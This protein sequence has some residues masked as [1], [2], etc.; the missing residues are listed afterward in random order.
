MLAAGLAAGGGAPANATSLGMETAGP[1]HPTHRFAA[2]PHVKVQ[3][4]YQQHSGGWHSLAKFVN[5]GVEVVND[6]GGGLHA[7]VGGKWHRLGTFT[8][9]LR[10]W[11]CADVTI[12]AVANHLTV[13]VNGTRVGSLTTSIVPETTVQV[14][15]ATDAFSSDPYVLDDVRIDTSDYSLTEPGPPTVEPAVPTGLKVVSAHGG[16]VELDWDDNTGSFGHYQVYRNNALIADGPAESRFVDTG[17]TVGA[18]YEYRVSAGSRPVYGNWTAGVS[19]VVRPGGPPAATPPVTGKPSM[20]TGLKVVAAH[21]S[22]VEL[23]WDDNA[24]S[25]GHYQVYRNNKMIADGPAESRFVDTAVTVGATYEYR[26]GAGSRPFYGD[27]STGVSATVR[28]GGPP[29][30]APP[31]TTRPSMPTGLKV[32]AA[33]GSGVEL[34]WDDNAGSFGH[35]QVYRDNKM[36]ADGPSESRFVDTV[37]TPGA[38]Y[39]YRVGA[40]SR[41][42]YGDW[43]AGVSATVRPGVAPA[44]P[45][46]TPSP[47]P[48]PTETPAPT[49]APTETPAP[50]PAPTETPAPTPAPTET[51]S[52][53]PT[54]SATPTPTVTPTPTATPTPAPPAPS[55]VW[56][57]NY[58]AITRLTDVKPAWQEEQEPSV[59]GILQNT[60][61]RTVGGAE[62]PGS[63]VWKPSGRAM[64]VELRPFAGGAGDSLTTSG[65]TANRAEAYGRHAP[66]STTPPASWPDPVGSERWY[67][68]SMYT[69]SDFATSNLW[70]VFTQWKGFRGGSPPL[71]LEMAGDRVQLVSNPFRVRQDLGS[72]SSLKGGWSRF[73]MGVKW[74]NS[75]AGWVEMWRALP[76]G[77]MQQV[78]ARRSM[79]TMETINGQADPIYLKQG[80][81]RDTAWTTTN[82]LFYGP[83]KIAT[84]RAAVE[85]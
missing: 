55:L 71:A 4:C 19:T 65:Y 18:T 39:E 46:P 49:P 56:H 64:R 28:P 43:T 12:D 42:L 1:S 23:D 6:G 15:D 27:W 84:S 3:F 40:G 5:S 54:P 24:G 9:Q 26:V 34:D 79:Q 44:A 59:G 29:A 70:M 33:Y 20:P 14:G 16:A 21:G 48:T 72:V 51:P 58:D 78:M 73:V 82:T 36:I 57:A 11:Y 8:G 66:S 13:D 80:I 32:V 68:W 63:G 85:R 41:P 52:P 74:S 50:T 25:F 17:A 81:Y 75:G 67:G 10:R 77:T 37:V 22:G 62:L 69:P 35:Y 60:R 31:V 83:M 38:T 45:T 30:A 53:S 61:M 2:S 47:T 7:I 76:D